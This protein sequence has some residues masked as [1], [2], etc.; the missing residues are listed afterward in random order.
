MSST[1]LGPTGKP[2]RRDRRQTMTQERLQQSR[3]GQMRATSPRKIGDGPAAFSLSMTVEL[4]P[5][6]WDTNSFYRRLGLEPDCERI[7]IAAAFTDAPRPTAEADL[8]YTTAAKALLKK[9]VR[10]RYDSIP[11]GAFFGDDPDLDDARTSV[12]DEDGLASPTLNEWAI[13]ADP[14]VSDEV[15]KAWDPTPLRTEITQ[16]LSNWGSRFDSPCIGLGITRTNPRWDMVG[17]FPVLFFGVDTEVTRE[18][19]VRVANAF[20]AATTQP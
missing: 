7:D 1:L 15:A 10:R 4:Q 11:L 12:D 17:N 20:I 18:Y 16:A 13:Y 5:F 19:I 14:C 8:Y 2:L 3:L 9:D 6:R